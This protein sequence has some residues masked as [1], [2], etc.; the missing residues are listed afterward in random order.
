MSDMNIILIGPPGAGKGTQAAF[1]CQE[2]SIPH[3]S[4]GD[5]LR[6]AVKGG[7]AL[8]LLAKSYMDSG[9]LVPDDVTIGIVRER[10]GQED[11]RSGFLLDGF[12]RTIPQALA[13]EEALN[14]LKR[15]IS[16]VINI[17]V[18]HDELIRRL[19]G[20]LVC[21]SCGATYHTMFNPSPK[22]QHCGLC[23]GTLYQRSDDSEETA[24]ARLQVYLRQTAPLLEYYEKTGKLR[25]IDGLLPISEVT[26]RLRT[27][28][29]ERLHDQS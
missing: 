3:I 11:A 2:L 19:T 6:A 12:P 28:L 14:G 29:A 10:L 7:T 22:G 17:V 18:P 26:E 9:Q 24:L 25:N 16:L 15:D 13:L 27:V 4:S 23:G 20:R 8:G 1:L 5:M 21:K